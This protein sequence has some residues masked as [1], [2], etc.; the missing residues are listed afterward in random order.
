M[1]QLK[2][3]RLEYSF[4][5]SQ[6]QQRELELHPL[7]H[8]VILAEQFEEA[9]IQDTVNMDDIR[10]QV[11][12]NKSIQAR[13]QSGQSP[14][15]FYAPAVPSFLSTTIS[16]GQTVPEY[17]DISTKLKSEIE[18]N[19]VNTNAR[20]IKSALVKGVW[21]VIFFWHKGFKNTEVRSWKKHHLLF[22]ELQ[23]ISIS[24]ILYLCHSYYRI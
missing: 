20:L 15:C 4:D 16:L 10:S 22:V 2:V 23:S 1:P 11:M 3:P 6:Q 7:Q 21:K 5:L 19:K 8:P 13:Q 12:S 9:V 14:T 17:E 24:C 18:D